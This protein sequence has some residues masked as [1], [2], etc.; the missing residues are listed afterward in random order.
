MPI[1]DILR[2]ILIVPGHKPDWMR[3]APGLG[4]DALMFDLEDPVPVDAK[5]DARAAAGAVVEDAGATSVPIFVRVNGWGTGHLLHDLHAVVG[6]GLHGVALPKT[7]QAGDVIALDRVLSELEAAR[8]LPVGSIEVYPILE[9][10]R[11]MRESHAVFT[12]SARVRRG[13]GV[14][15]ATPGGDFY[16]ATGSTYTDEGLESLY[17]SSK[18]VLDAR[19]AGFDSIIGGVVTDLTGTEL[20]R[21]VMTRLRTIGANGAFAIHPSQVPVLNE[22]FSPSADDI[23]EAVA[24]LVAMADGVARGDAAVRHRGRM[25][26]YAHVRTARDLLDQAAR[27]GLEVPDHPEVDVLSYGGAP[28]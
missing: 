15:A 25:I 7:D 5:A 19:S 4:A 21:T 18:I 22:V 2:S 10:A 28:G 1:A 24:T 26:D 6:P 8:G 3:K 20:L 14:I 12:S 27:W 13:S 17:V 23:A 11:S 16:R 9:T